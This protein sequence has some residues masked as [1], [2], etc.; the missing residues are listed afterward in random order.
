MKTATRN[1]TP[2]MIALLCLALPNW[3]R[4]T[5]ETYAPMEPT[6][7]EMGHETKA[8]ENTPARYNKASGII[9]MDIRNQS[10]EHLGHI[11]DVVF[12]LKTERVSYAVIST[13][14]KIMMGIDEK[15]LA[16]P[17]NALTVSSDGKSLVLNADKS[18]VETAQGF[19]RH[20]WPSVMSPSWGA[21]PFWQQTTEMP[22]ATAAPAKETEGTPKADVK[23]ES[24]PD[25]E[26]E[27]KPDMEPESKADT[28][29]ESAPSTG[30]E[31]KSDMEPEAEPDV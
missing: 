5:D 13:A 22:A 15:L 24:K 21:Q 4:A 18:K 29:E 12:D 11:K 10:D 19:D 28:D 16:V 25:M 7:H 20:D 26:Q 1:L 8:S 30:P 3:A 6:S 9:G 14:P 17:L 23:S 2:A 31:S 27:S